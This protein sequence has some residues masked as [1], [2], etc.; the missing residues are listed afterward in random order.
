MYVRTPF[1]HSIALIKGLPHLQCDGK[2]CG[3]NSDFCNR[4]K[5]DWNIVSF[6]FDENDRTF[7][8]HVDSS[9]KYRGVYKFQMNLDSLFKSELTLKFDETRIKEISRPIEI[10]DVGELQ[11]FTIRHSI[12]IS[13][14]SS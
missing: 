1:H 7:T 2:F 4:T 10:H 12:Y 14:I 6:G 9:F 3:C 8:I 13:I 5:T 11:N